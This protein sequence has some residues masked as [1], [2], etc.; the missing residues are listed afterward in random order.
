MTTETAQVHDKALIRQLIN[1][2]MKAICTEHRERI[3]SYYAT[4][5]AIFDLKPPLPIKN[6]AVHEAG[7][8]CDTDSFDIEIRDLGTF[9]SGDLALAYWLWRV[10]ETEKD[11]PAI[12]SWIRNIGAYQRYQ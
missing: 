8:C 7:Q 5:A 11:H 2:Q 10:T 9:V 6:T 4:E 3:I 12:K 1:D